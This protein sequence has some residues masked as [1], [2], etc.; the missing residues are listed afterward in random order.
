[1][2]EPAFD[3][4]PE[5]QEPRPIPPPAGDMSI[6]EFSAAQQRALKPIEERLGMR[7]LRGCVY[8]NT[9]PCPEV[10]LAVVPFA[11]GGKQGTVV[12]S[13]T[14]MLSISKVTDCLLYTS[15]RRQCSGRTVHQRALH[16]RT[17]GNGAVELH[18]S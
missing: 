16:A 11:P 18:G 6:P 3:G 9:E 12:L 4:P 7:I 2:P 1:M 13:T 14:D 8:E 5:P 10:W 15:R 17:D